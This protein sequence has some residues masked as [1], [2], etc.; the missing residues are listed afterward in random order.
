M[1]H[2]DAR[3][4]PVESG[5][6]DLVLTSPPCINVHNYHQKCQRSV[7]A[8]EWDVLAVA[9]SE[10]GSNRQNRG[11]VSSRSLQYSLDMALALR[12]MAR[13]ARRGSRLILVLGASLRLET[14]ARENDGQTGCQRTIMRHYGA[15]T[16]AT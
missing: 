8:L 7:E 10:I 15:E 3:A 5:S 1:H 14:A 9:R 11:T 13:V 16:S 2:A 12:E 4:L 6:A